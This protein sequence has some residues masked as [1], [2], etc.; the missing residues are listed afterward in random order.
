MA[1]SARAADSVHVG[2]KVLSRQGQVE[3]DD[4][5]DAA[6]V[7]PAGRHVGCHQNTAGSRPEFLQ[8]RLPLGLRPI[9]V[10]VLGE[11]GG[12]LLV[13]LGI[14]GPAAAEAVLEPHGRA[15][16]LDEDQRPAVALGQGLGRQAEL[17]P[18][19][20]GGQDQPLLDVFDG[21]PHPADGDP[22]V[23]PEEGRGQL[24]HLGGE[25][26]REQQGLAALLGGHVG[27]LDDAADLGLEAHVEHAVALVE[28]EEGDGRHGD[29]AAVDEVVEAAGRGHDDVAPEGQVPHL[30]LLVGTAVNHHRAERRFEGE[31]LRLE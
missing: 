2:V 31:L 13:G 10:D 14:A 3:I 8:R 12:E 24:L 6:D 5:L 30:L 23:R 11:D 25:G 17:L 7:Q 29:D 15:L 4:V 16:L 28:D 1:S 19:V 18:L 20:G 27:L 21:R 9:A 22:H 26:G